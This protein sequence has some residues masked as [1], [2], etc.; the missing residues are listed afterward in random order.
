M[1]VL[2]FVI[3]DGGIGDWF[4]DCRGD[5]FFSGRDSGGGGWIGNFGA[6]EGN[7]EEKYLISN[8]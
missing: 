7:E 4:E 1:V 3:I 6:S 5:Y 8:Y 2:P